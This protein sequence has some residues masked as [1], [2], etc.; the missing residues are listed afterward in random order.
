MKAIT[1]AIMKFIIRSPF[2]VLVTLTCPFAAVM[3][4]ATDSR[5]VFRDE[6]RFAVEAV[7]DVW[8]GRD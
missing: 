6:I 1:T 2:A 3:S 4:W 5:A 7:V 8:C